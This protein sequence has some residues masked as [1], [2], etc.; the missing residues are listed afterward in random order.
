MTGYH[1]CPPPDK[2]APPSPETVSRR[3]ASIVKPNE[4]LTC[5]IERAPDDSACVFHRKGRFLYSAA[6][7][8]EAARGA[9]LSEIRLTECA[10]R[11]EVGKDRRGF[12]A[13][14]A[15]AA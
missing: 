13:L 7:R 2:M 4:I 12:V 14:F 8:R 11:R 5:P 9:G 10:L 15:L 1:D 6:H 3:C